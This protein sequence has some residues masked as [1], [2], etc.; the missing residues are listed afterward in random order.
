MTSQDLP[1][2]IPSSVY[3]NMRDF[4]GPTF[5]GALCQAVETGVVLTQCLR[6]SSRARSKEGTLVKACVAFVTVLSV[7]QTGIGFYGAW[8]QLIVHFGDYTVAAIPNWTS[9]ILPVM[10]VMLAAPVQGFLIWRC[11]LLTK[12]SKPL[13]VAFLLFYA[14]SIAFAIA[15]V[16]R[17]FSFD[18]EGLYIAVGE[19]LEAGQPIPETQMDPIFLCCLVFPAT[20]DTALTTILFIFLWRS[21]TDV[22]TSRF[23]RTLT[24]LMFVIWEAALPPTVC[25]IAALITYV[26]MFRRSFW[27]LYFVCVLGQQYVIALF[28]TVNGFHDVKKRDSEADRAVSVPDVS[29]S[30]S[31]FSTGTRTRTANTNTGIGT[32]SGTTTNTG[33]DI[34]STWARDASASF[35]VTFSVVRE[36]EFS[37]LAS[38]SAATSGPSESMKAGGGGHEAIALVSTR[39]PPPVRV[40]FEPGVQAIQ[41]PMR[42]EEED[43]EKGGACVDHLD[44]D[45]FMDFEKADAESQ[46]VDAAVPSLPRLSFQSTGSD[47]RTRSR[48]L[49]AGLRL[50]RRTKAGT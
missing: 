26:T 13:L 44:G 41:T 11:W 9:K 5:L 14:A 50:G 1:S 42:E 33:E 38:G 6:F 47:T 2:N 20:M 34:L 4:A 12:R 48:P 25:A 31:A 18:F 21:R 49:W 27:D 23:R 8:A 29:F 22:V 35:A 46:D 36:D 32:Y 37:E 24:S 10:N 30:T 7:V 15:T 16:L 19:A 17:V 45:D 3:P 43:V 39:S 28:V 40:S